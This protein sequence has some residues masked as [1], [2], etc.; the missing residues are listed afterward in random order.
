MLVSHIWFSDHSI[1]HL[2]LGA[3]A[4]GRVRP[5]G[6]IG[7]PVGEV[8][9]FL[10]Y[11]W[12]AKSPGLNVTRKFFHTHKDE[13]DALEARILGATVRSATLSEHGLQIQICLSSGVTLS[14]ASPEDEEP[15]W[16]VGLNGYRDGWPGIEGGKLLFRIGN[17]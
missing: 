11:D 13:R 4:A 16:D 5:N 3:L 17:T 15:D 8:T 2:E 9:V 6:S 1:C 7:N 14:S 10:G 12:E